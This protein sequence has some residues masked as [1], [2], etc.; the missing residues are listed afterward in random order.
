[1]NEEQTFI[2]NVALAGRSLF[3]TGPGGVGKSYM[4]H[5]IRNQLRHKNVHV[6]ALTGCAA[7]LIKGT[8]LHSWAG[9]K[10]SNF[11]K[12]AE[13]I[14]DTMSKKIL[15]RWKKTH[16]LVIDEVSMLSKELFEKLNEIGQIVRNNSRPF[17]GIQLIFSGDFFQL[18]PVVKSEIDDTE[19]FAFCSPVWNTLFCNTTFELTQI[20]RQK[21]E[22]FIRILNKIRNGNIDEEVITTLESRMN[23]DTTDNIEP[24]Q[25]MCMRHEVNRINNEQ[26]IELEDDI[27]VHKWSTKTSGTN[28]N[29]ITVKQWEND[30]QCEK[31]L[32]LAIGAQVVLLHNKFQEDFELINGSRG[33]I[34]GFNDDGDPIVQFK[35]FTLEIPKHVWEFETYNGD[36][37]HS[38]SQYPLKL[39]WALTVHKSQGMTLD[40]VVLDISNIFEEGQAYVALSRVKSLDGLYIKNMNAHKIKANKTVLKYF[41]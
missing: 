34:E 35:T 29:K 22:I 12:S 41:A 33:V 11:D 20:M 31:T 38:V 8:T 14:V 26:M 23:L 24:T 27:Q 10:I 28:I 6:T 1:M 37:K 2:L 9:L 17:G 36:L 5:H 4:I 18:P 15:W 19:K 25:L 30:C 21:D 13:F 7:V 3:M 39:A 32:F 16:V 40:S